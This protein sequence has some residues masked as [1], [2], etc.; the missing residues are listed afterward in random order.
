M[1]A[2]NLIG[3]VWCEGDGWTPVLHPFTGETLER[4]A[5]AT[6]PQVELAIAR[7]VTSM[8]TLRELTA[9]DRAQILRTIAASIHEQS[10]SLS[11][12]LS[13]EAGKPIAQARGEVARASETFR[14]AAEE[15]RSQRGESLELDA[16]KSGAGKWGVIRRFPVGPV[17]AITPFN[18]PLN[19][20][21]HKIA[22]AIAVG[23]PVVVK[24]ADKTPLSALALAKIIE[25]A[26]WPPGA[27]SVL[28]TT[29]ERAA[30]L[31]DDPRMRLLT[32]TGSGAVG[33][34]LR[35]RAGHKKVLLELG[36]DAAVIVS[37]RGPAPGEADWNAMVRRIALGAFAYGGQV[38]ISVQ[39]VFVHA[40]RYEAF[41][42][43][44]VDAVHTHV[45][46]GPPE[47]ED[48]IMSAL[49]DDR[50][51]DKTQ[52]FV[53]DALARGAKLLTGGHREDEGSGRLFDPMVMVNVPDDALL[54]REEVF[55]PVV[56]LW[57]YDTL[58][59]AFE[60]VNASPYG[61]QAG[62]YTHDLREANRAFERLE[63][64]AVLVGEIPT[65]RVDQMPYGGVKASGLGREGLKDTLAEYTEPRLCVLP[66]A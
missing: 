43:S 40:S 26:G 16:A 11:A 3:G 36:G 51:V 28:N 55:G 17:S 31:V 64:G 18:F 62:I 33:W 59:E 23:C 37:D 7:A 1:G 29:I 50:A 58:D 5:V 9:H 13:A 44:L 32:F 41:V 47:D 27:L 48:A 38:C 21:A 35:A 25:D 4:V 34:A 65:W 60:R 10:Q 52:A 19:L 20:V 45:R 12:T 54:S 6:A 46:V 15:L 24:P 2:S 53:A 63:V 8:D 57:P 30:P 39:R 61:L 42:E 66:R 49:I 56:A 22:P 14:F